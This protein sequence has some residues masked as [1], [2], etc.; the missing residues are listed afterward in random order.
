[1]GYGT[2]AIMAVPAH[3]QRDFEFAPQV[4]PAD[5][6]GDR[7]ARGRRSRHH[8]GGLHRRRRHGQLR[9]LRR[10]AGSGR[11][12]RRPSSMAGARAAG[13][14]DRQLPAARL[15]ASAGSATGACP[16]PIIYCDTCGAVPVPDDQLPVLLPDRRGLS[17]HRRRAVAAGPR[18]GLRA[19]HLPALRRRRR[20]ARPTPWTPSSARP[21]IFLRYPILAG[22]H[23]GLR[24][25]RPPSTGCRW[26][27]T[28]AAPSTP[29]CTCSTPASSPR[30]CADAGLPLVRRAVHATCATRA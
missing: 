28:S 17:A 19:H 18:R 13:Q 3:D 9:P 20:G 2:G 30:C 6:R 5:H 15:A 23:G 27:C 4:R 29:S 14:A 26:T 21:G 7:A 25:R 11:G 1:M 16:I 22:R 8:G 24:P 10:P 12:H